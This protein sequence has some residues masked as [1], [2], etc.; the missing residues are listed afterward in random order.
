MYLIVFLMGIVWTIALTFNTRILNNDNSRLIYVFMISF[1]V[2][3][4]WGY[5]VKAITVDISVIPFYALGTGT[6]STIGFYLYKKI[7]KRR[8]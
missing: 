5:L 2:S 3:I 8:K 6:G 4:I 7:N 1:I